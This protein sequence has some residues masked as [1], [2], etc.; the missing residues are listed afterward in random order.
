MQ[1]DAGNLADIDCLFDIVKNEKGRID[2]LSASA[3]VGELSKPLGSIT[4]KGYDDKFNVNVRG[5][6]FTKDT[7]DNTV[8][9]VTSKYYSRKMLMANNH[10]RHMIFHYPSL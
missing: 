7:R 4:K 2:V 10:N 1:G 9:S 6:L 5:T 3:D 8:S